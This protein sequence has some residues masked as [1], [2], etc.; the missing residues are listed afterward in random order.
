MD[1]SGCIITYPVEG[2]RENALKSAIR[3]G[4]K[5]VILMHE[6]DSYIDLFNKL[7]LITDVK[8]ILKDDVSLVVGSVANLILDAKKDHDV[9]VLLLPNDPIITTGIYIAACMEKVKVIAPVSG[10]EM[11]YLTLPIFP[12]ANLNKNET[13]ILTKIIENEEISTKNLFDIIKKG[14]NSNILC[15]GQYKV[16]KERSSLRHIQRILNKLEKMELI[17][18]EKRGIYFIWKSTPFGRLIFKQGDRRKY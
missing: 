6:A 1:K 17:S 11:K 4:V 14:E 15:S 18:K 9:S 7:G 10:L 13:L 5:K 2:H 3:L 12:F 16:V 8:P